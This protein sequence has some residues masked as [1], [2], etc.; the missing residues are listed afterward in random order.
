V[1]PQMFSLLLFALELYLLE[2][3]RARPRV[4]LVIPLLMPLWAN[5]HGAFIV[6]LGLLVIEVAAAAWRRDRPGVV[7]YA[8]V[9]VAS[10]AGLLANPWGTRVFGYAL[11]IPANRVVSGL[12]VEWAPMNVRELPGLLLLPAIGVLV[13]AVVRSPAPQCVPEHLLRMAL[14]GGLAFWAVRGVAWFGLALP[15]ALCALARQHPPRPADADRGVPALNV[16]VLA[17]LVLAL[18]AAA[19][20]VHRTL[21]G[22]RPEVTAAPEAAADW[23]AANPHPGRM[24]NYQPWGSYLE[25]RLGPRT[26][27]GFDSRIELAPVDRWDRYLDVVAGRWDAERLLDGWSVD[28]VVT[29]RRAT[30]ALI[31][32]LEGSGRWRLAFSSDDQR[33]Y[34]RVEG[35]TTARASSLPRAP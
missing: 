33:I 23:L 11:S 29:S 2:V 3:A 24:F 19:P 10:I 17:A 16:L 13:V 34:E 25:L 9:T 8:L 18:A 32:L 15:V 20:P 26:Q 27:V 12:I 5:L 22:S 6:G 7:R 21:V 14:L 30:P 35:R 31:E 28:R 1:R 4:A